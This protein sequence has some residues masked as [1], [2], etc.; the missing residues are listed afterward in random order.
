MPLAKTLP[1]ATPPLPTQADTKEQKTIDKLTLPVEYRFK[2][3]GLPDGSKAILLVP[4][5]EESERRRKDERHGEAD[6][7]EP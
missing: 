6:V 3:Q 1:L 4:S 7:D 2:Y 5:V